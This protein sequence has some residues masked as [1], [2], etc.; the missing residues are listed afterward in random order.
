MWLL[1]PDEFSTLRDNRGLKNSW[2]K[3]IIY[4]ILFM[5]N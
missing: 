3:M 4:D 5:I 1:S 2:G